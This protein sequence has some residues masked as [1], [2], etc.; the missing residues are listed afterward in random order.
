MRMS[1]LLC[2]GSFL[3]LACHDPVPPAPEEVPGQQEGE[4]RIIGGKLAASPSFFA[5]LALEGSTDIFCGASLIAPDVLLTAAH[6]LEDLE[7]PLI[8][9]PRP[10]DH[11][12]L[13]ASKALTV[14]RVLVHFAY[15][16]VAITNDLGLIFL[17]AGTS[18]AIEGFTPIPLT[19]DLSEPEVHPTLKPV[20]MGFGNLSSYGSLPS[21]QL[22][23]VSIPVLSLATCRG[24]DSAYEDLSADQICAGELDQGGHDSCW[25]DSGGP[26]VSAPE[27]GTPS[28]LGV[29]SWGLGC[30]QKSQPGIYTRVA[31]YRSWIEMAIRQPAPQVGASLIAQRC[32]WQARDSADRNVAAITWTEDRWLRFPGQDFLAPALSLTQLEKGA[33]TPK[34]LR[35]GKTAAQDE[36]DAGEEDTSVLTRCE[37]APGL[38][39]SLGRTTS[40][41][42]QY[43]STIEKS[44]ATERRPILVANTWQ[45]ISCDAASLDWYGTSGTLKLKD[46]LRDVLSAVEADQWRDA[47]IQSACEH[48]GLGF[49]VLTQ[50][51]GEA[52]LQL[53]TSAAPPLFLGLSD[54]RGFLHLSLEKGKKQ[55][56]VFDNQTGEDI[57]SFALTCPFAFTLIAADGRRYEAA[58][59]K[60]GHKLLFLYEDDIL[61]YI[62]QGRGR[63]FIWEAASPLRAGASCQVN[64]EELNLEAYTGPT[65]PA[66]TRR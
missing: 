39:L 26:L 16:P 15:D 33:F 3:L 11:E 24:L 62:P 28:L 34:S 12:A 2:L 42:D 7:S 57:Y 10:V 49:R 48:E 52:A 23:R 22:R 61:G 38:A 51:D 37:P 17:K 55:R 9:Y 13:D 1:Q 53:T 59:V 35:R 40:E 66:L 19:Q 41:T 20:V 14:D 4:L 58:P 54:L 45:S 25:G 43:E 8:V 65:A 18:A 60:D 63:S 21:D 30:A 27:L 56:L 29:V 31:A 50:P 36:E 46:G 32:Y 5:G 64:G 44:G 47:S 6:C